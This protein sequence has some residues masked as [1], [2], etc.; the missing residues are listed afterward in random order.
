[1]H[2]SKQ[3]MTPPG[4]ARGAGA[5]GGGDNGGDRGCRGPQ[6]A[7]SVPYWQSGYSAPGPPSS[8]KPSEAYVGIPMQLLRHT[9]PG[10][11]DGGGGAGGNGGGEGG[12]GGDFGGE[13]AGGGI[14]GG[15]ARQGRG[16][17]S[18]QSEP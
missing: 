5:G 4:N 6:S 2:V 8:Q 14:D 10:R 17:Q 11:R 15:D 7:Q 9:Y 18:V 3:V 12:G 13:G 16:P 1:M